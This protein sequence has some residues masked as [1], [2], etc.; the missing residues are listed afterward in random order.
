MCES[1]QS[2]SDNKYAKLNKKKQLNLQKQSNEWGSFSKS[3]QEF[4][5]VAWFLFAYFFFFLIIR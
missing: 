3:T 4:A 5:L 1:K 2:F